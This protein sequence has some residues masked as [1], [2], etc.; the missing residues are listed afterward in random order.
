MLGAFFGGGSAQVIIKAGF[1]LS[2]MSEFTL[3]L[4]SIG[5]T[6]KLLT[7]DIYQ[8]VLAVTIISMALGPFIINFSDKIAPKLGKRLSKRLRAKSDDAI[9]CD[10]IKDH[11]IIAGYGPSGRNVAHSATL[12]HIP[13]RVIELNP[14]TVKEEREKG[15]PILYGD[16]GQSEVL[17]H[18]GIMSARICVI[19]IDNLFATQQAVKMARELNPAVH[20]IARTRFLGEVEN[21]IEIGAH[22]V[23]S[24]EFETS[25]EI[26]S[27]VLHSY[28][29]P[30]DEIHKIT[31]EIRSGS[32]E[33][34]RSLQKIPYR[35]ADVHSMQ[36]DMDI[37]TIRIT[38][39]SPYCN[40]MIKDTS[41]RTTHNLT[42]IA[43]KRGKSVIPV[44]AADEAILAGDVVMIFGKP[45]DVIRAFPSESDEK[46][47]GCAVVLPLEEKPPEGS[48][49]V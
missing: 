28:L 23:I 21:L 19:V 42:I 32:Y 25:I 18:A 7:N 15:V 20:I 48:P 38:P 30:R 26:F 33:M 11:I 14:D 41:L 39:S 2:F 3:I 29:M 40:V 35:L 13:Y 6:A 34:Y 17:V 36:E 44:P 31:S 22:E 24:E 4:A 8:I 49:G 16:A 46:I 37:E 10:E 5:L 45:E 12:A 47:K 9:E 1:H 27:R 43:I